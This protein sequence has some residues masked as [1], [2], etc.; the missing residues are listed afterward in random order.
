M[1]LQKE[2][3]QILARDTKPTPS[4]QTE[5]GIM[6]NTFRTPPNRPSGCIRVQKL[7]DSLPSLQIEKHRRAKPKSQIDRYYFK[8]EGLTWKGLTQAQLYEIHMR[9][10]Q[11]L[12]GEKQPDYNNR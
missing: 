12:E 10:G 2:D 4:G 7:C 9:I 11:F 6:L 5:L 1:T 3:M 8:I